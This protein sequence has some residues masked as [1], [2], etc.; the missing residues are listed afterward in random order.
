ML[1]QRASELDLPLQLSAYEP[2]RDPV[3]NGPGQLTIL[4]TPA[5]VPVRCGHL[6]SGN[7]D[8]V[9]DTLRHAVRGCLESR[10]H[11]LVT[12][13][14][15]KGVINEGGIPFTGHTEFIA[16]LC[17]TEPVMM[18]ATP[19]LRVALVTTHLPLAN[20]SAAI[21]RPRLTRVLNTLHHDLIERFGIDRPRILVCGLN[22]HAG[23]GGHLGQEE[24][25]VI[26]P[27][28]ETLRREG[29]DLYGPLPADTLFIPR[30]LR[31]ADAILA[32]YHDQG[33][34]VLKHMGFGRAV[35]VTLGLPLIRTSVDHGTA[36]DLAGTGSADSG[37]LEAALD[38]A[39]SLCFRVKFGG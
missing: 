35:N 15:H 28:L 8:Y 2:E 1:L 6:E 36:L 7:A 27:V 18:L 38:M 16:G 39:I 12:G 17:G 22:P 13:P 30:Y 3:P 20:V 32:M 25:T 4:H 26:A 34:P 31:Q 10:F 37:S 9:V 14:V 23:E 24:L 5:P 19:G 33:L 29:M 11:A 21:T